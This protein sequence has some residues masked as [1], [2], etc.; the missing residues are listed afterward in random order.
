MTASLMDNI[1]IKLGLDPE[2]QNQFCFQSAIGSPDGWNAITSCGVHMAVPR[3]LKC[4]KGIKC[5]KGLKLLHHTSVM[6]FKIED[7]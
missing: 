2:S 4:D 3:S 1:I 5:T 6:H 7:A